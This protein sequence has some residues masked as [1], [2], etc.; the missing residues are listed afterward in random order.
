MRDVYPW[1]YSN[2]ACREA[3]LIDVP[4]P[5]IGDFQS[6]RIDVSRAVNAMSTALQCEAYDLVNEEYELAA[7]ERE[8]SQ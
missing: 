8:L 7:R 1:R 6:L 2:E 3:R 5:L 4:S